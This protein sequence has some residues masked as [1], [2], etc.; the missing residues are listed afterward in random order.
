MWW[1][2]FQ[3]INRQPSKRLISNRQRVS[4]LPPPPPPRHW[5]RLLSV[6]VLQIT[7]TIISTNAILAVYVNYSTYFGTDECE[8][9]PWGLGTPFILAYSCKILFTLLLRCAKPWHRYR[10]SR[11]PKKLS[12]TALSI[13]SSC[14]PMGS[15]K[16]FPPEENTTLFSVKLAVS[17][18]DSLNVLMSTDKEALNP[19]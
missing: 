9:V 16:S 6:F 17:V 4:S 2:S 19:P 12:W 3:K 7:V 15:G 11:T 8:I 13:G 10:W 18:L 5:D 1:T 14:N